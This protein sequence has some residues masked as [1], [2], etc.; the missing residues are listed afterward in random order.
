[1]RAGVPVIVSDAAGN[2]DTVD[3]GVSGLVVP[4]DDP[5]R[6]AEAIVAVIEDP[7]LRERLI[8]GGRTALE[9]FDVRRMAAATRRVY[10][11][12]LDERARRF[13]TRRMHRYRATATGSL[14]QRR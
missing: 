12:V 5:V 4:T 2:R 3:S 1:M 14:V 10:E 6:L 13:T 11:D 9:R 8:Q 7:G